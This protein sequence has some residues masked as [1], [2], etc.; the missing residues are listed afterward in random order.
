MCKSICWT[1]WCS[2]ASF[3]PFWS[4]AVCA[5]ERENLP[6]A[7]SRLCSCSAFLKGAAKD[8][9]CQFCPP[10]KMKV[11]FLRISSV[12]GQQLWV[13]VPSSAKLDNLVRC[14]DAGSFGCVVHE[15]DHRQW[16]DLNYRHH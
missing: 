3:E 11:L 2:D 6:T 12:T 15:E 5:V 1:Q 8:L 9:I 16:T 4:L 14:R 13:S 7:K 10:W